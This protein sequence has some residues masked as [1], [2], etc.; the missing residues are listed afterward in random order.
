MFI[1][2]DVLDILR[3]LQFWDKLITRVVSLLPYAKVGVSYYQSI[4]KPRRYDLEGR[5][6]PERILCPACME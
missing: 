6:P 3:L 5:S 2:S 1:L 4:T